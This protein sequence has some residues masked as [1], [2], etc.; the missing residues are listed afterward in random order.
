MDWSKYFLVVGIFAD[1]HLQFF[2]VAVVDVV[3]VAVVDVV[4]VMSRIYGT[5]FTVRNEQQ[6]VKCEQNIHFEKTNLAKK[7]RW[8]DLSF[9]ETKV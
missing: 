8:S 3:V 2:A 7:A 9:F 4:V 6:Q 1:G 5:K